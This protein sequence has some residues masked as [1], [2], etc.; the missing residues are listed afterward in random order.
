[1]NGRIIA[2]LPAA[3]IR[4]GTLFVHAGLT[5][6]NVRQFGS[7]DDMN[8]IMRRVLN[9]VDRGHAIVGEHG[10]VWTRQNIYGGVAYLSMLLTRF[11]GD[12]R[13]ALAA[14]NAGPEAVAQ[15]RGIPPFRETQNYVTSIAAR[16]SLR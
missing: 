5:E 4:N 11:N 13:L 3:L 9:D 1:M 16:I 15:Y 12:T 2:N 14:Y 6:V 7:I 10:P 8:A